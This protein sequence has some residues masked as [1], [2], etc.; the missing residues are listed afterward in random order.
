MRKLIILFVV[1]CFALPMGL[2][3]QRDSVHNPLSHLTL[4][5]YYRHDIN[6]ARKPLD[7]SFAV[8]N[9]FLDYGST[10]GINTRAY[11][12]KK[13]SIRLGLNYM[14]NKVK[15]SNKPFSLTVTDNR[16]QAAEVLSIQSDGFQIPV[17]IEYRAFNANKLSGNIGAGFIKN[18][19][20]SLTLSVKQN[21]DVSKIEYWASP[22]GKNNFVLFPTFGWFY[23][24]NLTYK[25]SESIAFSIE[26]SVFKG[27]YEGYYFQGLQYGVATNIIY[28][29]I[30]H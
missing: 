18:F 8:P 5:Y 14:A 23:F 4:I 11:F 22:F 13:F 19:Q 10:I 24:V 9:S 3:A 15:Y 7:N 1:L 2:S 30:L 26:P 27:N 17:A 16:G 6:I 29:I 20:H 25:I 28:K 21:E 12:S